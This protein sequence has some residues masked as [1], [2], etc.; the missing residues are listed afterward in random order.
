MARKDAPR[1]AARKPG[2]RARRQ[3]RAARHRA[4]CRISS[5]ICRCA[6]RITRASFRSRR[7]RPGSSS[8]PRARVVSTDIQYRPRRQLVCLLEDGDDGGGGRA[9]LV[10]RF[11][12]FYPNQ[13]KALAPGRRVRVFG[14]VREGHFGREIVH[15]QFTVVEPG[16]PLPDRLT[17]VYPT[18]AGLAQETLRKVDRAR[19]RVRSRAHGRDAA[20]RARRARAHLWKF[21]DAVRFLHAPPPR[22]SPLDAARARRAH[23]SR[24]D[25]PQVRRARRAAAVAQGAPQGARGEARAGADRHA[26]R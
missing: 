26:A 1:D 25:A 21:G 3:A 16:T 15:P 20:G 12:H 10:L 6:T 9:Q 7:L 23:A 11:F 5:C 19:A 2:A 17:P 22:L 8:R 13:Q 14:E 4:R 18:T 24:V